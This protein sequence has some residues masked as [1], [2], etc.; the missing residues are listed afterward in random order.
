[1][2]MDFLGN[3]NRSWVRN[4]SVKPCFRGFREDVAIVSIVFVASGV[5]GSY[6]F[7]P[8]ARRIHECRLH[9]R[10]PILFGTEAIEN[11]HKAIAEAEVY[12]SYGIKNKAIQVLEEARRKSPSDDRLEK[13]LNQLKKAK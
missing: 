12:L 3:R 5:V 8:M 2:D 11:E 7:L 1:M 10:D 4:V 13:R 9:E 6:M